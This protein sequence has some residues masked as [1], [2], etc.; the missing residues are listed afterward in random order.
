MQKPKRVNLLNISEK[1]L[2]LILLG[3]GYIRMDE[4]LDAGDDFVARVLAE[5]INDLIEREFE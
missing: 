1:Q 4:L 2:E 5:K 3:L